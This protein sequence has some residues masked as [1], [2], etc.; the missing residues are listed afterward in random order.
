MSLTL[1]IKYSILQERSGLI[2]GYERAESMKL[3]KNNFNGLEPDVNSTDF[4]FYLIEPG[5]FRLVAHDDPRVHQTLLDRR[6][7][8]S[9][10]D[11]IAQHL[12]IEDVKVRLPFSVNTVHY[13][14]ADDETSFPG[15][16]I[17]QSIKS[18]YSLA[19]ERIGGLLISAA[20]VIAFICITILIFQCGSRSASSRREKHNRSMNK[21]LGKLAATLMQR[22]AE[23]IAP[24]TYFLPFNNSQQHHKSMNIENLETKYPPIGSA[25]STIPSVHQDQLCSTN[26]DQSLINSNN[27][28]YETQMLKMAVMFDDNN[29]V[30][31][32]NLNEKAWMK[33][34][35]RI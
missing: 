10:N 16:I 26:S 19:G 21:Q 11:V 22:Q 15:S 8:I 33:N 34:C 7:Q 25:F 24:Q 30:E 18:Q 9:L 1:S 23:T 5:S 13:L 32:H 29:S 35:H 6:A 12:K 28:E 3:R 20:I 27:K 14:M 2:P 31:E 17:L 4:W